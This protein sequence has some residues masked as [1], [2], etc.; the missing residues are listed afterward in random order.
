MRNPNK[1][2]TLWFSKFDS[3]S[4]VT[5]LDPLKANGKNCQS[6]GEA[7]MTRSR[8]E[9][10]PVTILKNQ[11]SSLKL[12]YSSVA[13]KNLQNF[14][15]P[16][17]VPI[18]SEMRTEKTVVSNTPRFTLE[19]YGRTLHRMGECA[20]AGS[21]ERAEALLRDML[22]KFETGSHS[23]RPDGACYNSVIHAYAQT[24][25]ADKA[26]SIL[27]L[28]FKDYQNGNEKAEPNVRVYT[29]VLHAWRKAKA[30]NAPERCEAILKEMYELSDTCILPACKPDTFSVTV[31]ILQNI[32]S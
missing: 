15:T 7:N 14:D 25:K 1:Y 8:Y 26:E 16:H 29:N 11:S 28:M 13:R 2:S 19:D 9:V 24:G 4:L 10:N 6:H 31:S 30:P 27:R 5:G 20:V 23:I 12:D 3:L 32:I 22:Q 18:S 21:A 17:I